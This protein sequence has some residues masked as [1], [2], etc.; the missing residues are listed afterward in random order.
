[1]GTWRDWSPEQAMLAQRLFG[2][3][4]VQFGDF[5]LKD[6]SRSP[7][8]INLCAEGQGG[9]LKPDTIELIGQVL[10]MLA[11]EK[12]LVFERIAGV[13]WAG[14]SIAEAFRKATEDDGDGLSLPHNLRLT[15]VGE[16]KERRIVGI[17]RVCALFA[18]YAHGTH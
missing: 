4:A 2:T 6:G 18:L 13:P 17:G 14:D 10:Y 1:M 3:G 8:Y 7:I 16:G 12:D 9:P 5:E 15:K 11:K